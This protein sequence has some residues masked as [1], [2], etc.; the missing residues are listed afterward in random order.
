M[1]YNGNQTEKVE[2]E[3]QKTLIANQKDT[4]QKISVTA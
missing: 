3:N 1:K 4:Y 2:I